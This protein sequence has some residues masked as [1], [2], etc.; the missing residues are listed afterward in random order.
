MIFA[1]YAVFVISFLLPIYTYAL[2]PIIIKLLPERKKC[3]IKES[4]TPSVSVIVMEGSDKAVVA[5]KLK[6]LLAQDYPRDK[7]DI[8]TVAQ[9]D[10]DKASGFTRALKSAKG[11]VIVVS[12]ATTVYDEHAVRSLVK[13]FSD[14][15]AGCVVGQLRKADVN[16][17]GG[18]ALWKYENYV[19]K[20]ESKIGAVSGANR[21]IYAFRKEII[22]DIPQNIIDIDFY[23]STY[24]TQVGYDVIMDTDAIAYE[25]TE[26]NKTGQFW[27]HV[28]DGKGY[29][30]ALCIFRRLLLPRKGSFVYI[31]HRVLKWLV[32]FNL[33]LLLLSNAVLACHSKLM[34]AL[35]WGQ[36]FLYA[37]LFI[38]NPE[39]SKHIKCVDRTLGKL[40][41]MLKYFLSFN[42]SLL[43]GFYE[44]FFNREC[45]KQK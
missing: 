30:Q 18:N 38:Y 29:Y 2:Y 7:L 41:S 27:R 22:N 5:T 37:F 23:I 20:L 45:F 19:R 42:I 36:I 15:H 28:N 10:Q 43:I 39:W 32:P 25:T 24:T 6:N 4:Y 1:V 11:C 34:M 9:E 35:L 13:H 12:D 33:I 14:E 16:G 44:F 21:A 8:I 17:N 26:D 3:C 40:F 31:S